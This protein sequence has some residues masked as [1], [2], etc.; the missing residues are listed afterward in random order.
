M[1]AIL[2]KLT[3]QKFNTLLEKIR[4]LEINTKERLSG[5]I[6]LTF[7]KAIDEP[8]FSV[9][10]ARL[11]KRLS[12]VSLTLYYHGFSVICNGISP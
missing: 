5:S 4:A 7:E 1:R 10:Y 9:A 6:D 12:D 11:C 3:P 8:N 2:N